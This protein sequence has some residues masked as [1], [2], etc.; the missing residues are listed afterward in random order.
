MRAVDVDLV[1]YADMAKWKP[2]HGDVIHKINLLNSWWGI[3]AGVTQNEQVIEVIQA[4]TPQILFG[5]GPAEQ[6]KRTVSIDVNKIKSNRG[7]TVIQNYGG[8]TIWFVN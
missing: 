5:L 7:Y 6:E 8:K 2:I 3:V 4:G 1:T